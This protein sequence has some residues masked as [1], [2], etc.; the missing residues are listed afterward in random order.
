MYFLNQV[1]HDF[2]CPECKHINIAQLVGSI[3]WTDITMLS[4]MSL[5]FEMV[6]ELTKLTSE[7]NGGVWW[8]RAI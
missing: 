6:L 4:I 3:D 1:S 2:L 8:L 7:C 5:V